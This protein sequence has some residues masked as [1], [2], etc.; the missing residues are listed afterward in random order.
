MAEP[1]TG[2]YQLDEPQITCCSLVV[3]RGD[4]PS[5][6]E[7]VDTAFD[8]I[9]QRVQEIVDGFRTLAGLSGRDNRCAAALL[10]VFS[11]MVGIIAPISHENLRLGQVIVHHSVIASV[12]RYLPGRD[13]GF[14]G[15]AAPVREEMDLGREP[16]I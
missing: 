15:Q 14:D 16:T 1:E 3:P 9:A 5:V 13:L 2:G 12:V 6:L 4:P 10:D 11:D 7:F 8:Q